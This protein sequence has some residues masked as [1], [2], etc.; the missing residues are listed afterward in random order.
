MIPDSWAK[1]NFGQF[2]KI[3]PGSPLVDILAILLDKPA[4]EVATMRFDVEDA[5][6]KLAFLETPVPQVSRETNLEETT[7]DRYEDLKF[8]TKDFKGTAE[9]FK[10]YPA[11]YAI[12]MDP[13]YDGDTADRHIGEVEKLPCGQVLGSVIHY[14][15]EIDRIEEKWGKLFPKSG[16]SAEQIA[17][18]YKQIDEYFKFY[19]TIQFMEASLPYNREQLLKW[20]VADF[21]YNLLYLAWK[22]EAA[23]KYSEGQA[24]KVREKTPKR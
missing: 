7:V 13:V 16:Y 21:K 4:S 14:I 1:V 9:D 12:F 11:I 17:A 23:K 18:G 19:G 2:L 24:A 10:Q 15:K 20:K 8:I 3:Q 6:R 5:M 22:N